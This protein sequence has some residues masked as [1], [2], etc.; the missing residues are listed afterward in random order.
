MASD[1][2]RAKYGFSCSRAIGQ[3]QRIETT[4]KRYSATPEKKMTF[5]QFE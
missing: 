5:L 3:L 1:R 2:V 4:A